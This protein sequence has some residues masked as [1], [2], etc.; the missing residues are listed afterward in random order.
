MTFWQDGIF[1]EVV[2]DDVGNVGVERLVV[3]DAGAEGVGEGDVAGAIGVEEAGDAEDGVAAEGE[4]VDEVV[5]DAA[6]D[7]VDPA[8]A[9][10]RAHVDDVVV[11]DEIAAFDQLDAHLAGEIGVLE[12]GGVE[13]AGREQD[14]VRLGSAF[15]GERAQGAEQQLRVLLD[16]ANVVA[17]EEAAGRCASSRG[18]W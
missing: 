11:D 17:A 18:G 14:D 16:G 1:G 3:G 4:R 8:Q 7:D 10:G 9:V 2:L 12:V 15:G 6:V 13:D 5:V